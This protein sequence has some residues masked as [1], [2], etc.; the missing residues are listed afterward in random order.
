MKNTTTSNP[1]ASLNYLLIAIYVI[2]FL[3]IVLLILGAVPMVG[4]LLFELKEN[5]AA[6][7]LH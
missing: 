5:A 3:F 2:A 7:M 1:D 6:R 4:G